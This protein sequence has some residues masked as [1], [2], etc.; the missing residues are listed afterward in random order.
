MNLKINLKKSL[1][2][3]YLQFA[4]AIEDVPFDENEVMQKEFVFEKKMGPI[5]VAALDLKYG[6]VCYQFEIND[7]YLEDILQ[8][9]YNHA[10]TIKKIFDGI[11]SIIAAFASMNGI[12]KEFE[13]VVQKY[14]VKEEVKKSA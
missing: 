5:Q 13:Q 8:V 10:D 12:E 6:I 14:N 1:I 3:K 2:C 9:F 11:K 7:N 4:C